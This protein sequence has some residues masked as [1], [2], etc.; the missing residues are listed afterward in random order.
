MTPRRTDAPDRSGEDGNTLI[1]FPFAVLVVLALGGIALDAAVAFQADRRALDEATSLANDIAGA[2]DPDA[3]LAGGSVVAIDVG[4][5]EAATTAANAR[6][7]PDLACAYTLPSPTQVRVEC[8]GTA[9]P[10]ILPAL[11]G[12]TTFDVGGVAVASATVG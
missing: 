9:S 2:I 4:F 12:L 10:I 5:A 1:L 8:A 6:L 7:G 11:G 3:F